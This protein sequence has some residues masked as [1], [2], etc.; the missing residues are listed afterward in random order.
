MQLAESFRSLTNTGSLFLAALRTDKGKAQTTW[1]GQSPGGTNVS[2][3]DHPHS[4]RP[5]VR[6]DQGFHQMREKALSSFWTLALKPDSIATI[7]TG[8]V[9]T[10]WRRKALGLSRELARSSSEWI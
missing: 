4:L 6:S 1:H 2:Q 7:R 9:S 5:I 8:K 10:R 3:L